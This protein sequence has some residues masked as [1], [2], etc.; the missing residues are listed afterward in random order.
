[1]TTRFEQP[2]PQLAQENP[3][4]DKYASNRRTQ[5]RL[6]GVYQRAANASERENRDFVRRNVAVLPREQNEADATTAPAAESLNKRIRQIAG[7]TVEEIDRVIL[8]LESARE[9]LRNEG[10]RLTREVAG[11][12]NLSQASRTAM[13]VIGDSLRQWM[14]EPIGYDRRSVDS[15][16]RD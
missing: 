6:N 14:D 13:K 4:P 7:D 11:Y 2:R 12:A 3:N 1:M 10:D 5:E 9:L 8:E 15:R 16:K